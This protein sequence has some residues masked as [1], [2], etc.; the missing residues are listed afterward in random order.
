MS[1]VVQAIATGVLLLWVGVLTVVL[2]HRCRQPWCDDGRPV[3]QR[4]RNGRI[5]FS[6]GSPPGTRA[7]AAPAPRPGRRSPRHSADAAAA[8]RAG[9]RHRADHP[10]RDQ[11]AR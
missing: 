9:R 6:W 2:W 1:S 4:L 11:L 3:Y 8:A 5:R 7:G 10:Y